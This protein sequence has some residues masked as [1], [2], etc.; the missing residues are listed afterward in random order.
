MTLSILESSDS[1]DTAGPSIEELEEKEVKLLSMT[2]GS[3]YSKIITEGWINEHRIRKEIVIY[4]QLARIDFRTEIDSKGGDG[5]FKI[6][7]PLGF[8]GKLM[9]HIPFGVE[10]R[11]FLKEPCRIN[12]FS[13]NHP[14]TFYAGRW[15]DYSC[16][17][18]GIALIS[19]P[20]RR[21]YDFD[22]DERIIKHILLKTRT[23]PT[24]GCWRHLSRLHEGKGIYS[25]NYSIYPHKG[26]WKKAEVHR[27][28]L[29]YQ[30]PLINRVFSKV[31]E[32]K[33]KGIALPDKISFMRIEPNNIVMT[34]FYKKSKQVIVRVYESQGRREKAKLIFPFIIGKVKETD[35]NGQHVKTSRRFN[36]TKQVLN[37]EIEPWEIVTFH[38]T[39]SGALENSYMD[40]LY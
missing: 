21:G 31:T 28:A 35:F 15:I 23:I 30:N 2:R 24:R 11:E 17:N 4:Q 9:A 10:E 32:R 12:I 27:R 8:D 39:P 5:V 20:G 6:K 3:L 38:L 36:I 7:F 40:I 18:F 37:F 16:P 29:E 26:D 33:T 13:E 22:S 19:S 25:F 1:F 34:G 14:H